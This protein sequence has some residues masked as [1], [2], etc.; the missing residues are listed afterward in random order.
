MRNFQERI[1]Y[2]IWPRSFKDSNDDGI[3]DLN[4][5]IEK[6]D[7]LQSLGVDTLWLSPVYATENADYGYDVTD[8][9]QINPE[10]G[11]ME[12]MEELIREAKRRH[13]EI[14][15]DLVASHT[16]D[17]H[18]W[19]QKALADPH[20]PQRQY[21]FFRKGKSGPRGKRLPPNNWMSAFGDEAWQWDQKSQE[22]ISPSLP[23]GNATSTGKTPTFVR[24]SM[25][26]CGFGWR[27]AL[28]VFAW[29]SSTPSVKPRGFP[30]QGTENP[31][32]FPLT[33]WCLCP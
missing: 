13:M 17:R 33:M 23:P 1:I 22:F 18:P 27:R 12:D 15:M 20:S 26:S 4:G 6:L 31:S 11:T 28:R 3:G 14:L 7:Y 21:Y 29:M 2:Q 30:M 16:S 19:F 24:G 10:Y 25:P 5:I 8:Y 9:Y 32:S